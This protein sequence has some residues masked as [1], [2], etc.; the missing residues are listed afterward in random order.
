MES[1]R[2][3]FL[4]EKYGIHD[5]R[6]EYTEEE[7]LNASNSK[8]HYIVY[9]VDEYG[10]IT[11]I[12]KEVKAFISKDKCVWVKDEE[13]TGYDNTYKPMVTLNFGK[14]VEPNVFTKL[15]HECKTVY[16]CF[17]D[18]YDKY[19]KIAKNELKENIYE[20]INSLQERIDSLKESV[21]DLEN[22]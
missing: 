11:F 10:E 20:Y 22:N 6:N 21:F 14:E 19:I 4:R 3:K 7:L 12:H 9:K 2:V 1:I 15:D 17:I 5:S 8:A 16:Y 13:I 18:D